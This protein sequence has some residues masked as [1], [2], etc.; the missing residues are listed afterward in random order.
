MIR[1]PDMLS[2]TDAARRL[3][4]HP[5]R[6]R[7]LLAAG[8]LTG[9]KLGERW[10][11]DGSS[12]RQRLADA[13]IPGRLL[14]PKDAWAT[15]LLACGEPTLWFSADTRWR[16]RTQLDERGLIGLAPRLRRRAHR[17]RYIAHPGILDRLAKDRSLSLTGI[18]AATAHGLDIA[19]GG[20]L[21]AYIP[22]AAHEPLVATYALEPAGF[23]EGNLCLRIVPDA[24]WRHVSSRSAAPLAA[25]ALDLAEE[26]DSRSARVG[27]ETL[28]ALDA[29]RL[30]RAR[31]VES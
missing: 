19:G 8:E 3:G 20:E 12:V 7:A 4:V 15:V 10:V 13:P 2:T 1:G 16:L 24:T 11:I 28:E 25:V 22:Q 17:E 31:P 27:H 26:P 18:S 21:D 9:Q 23:S 30:W 5:S 14:T 29:Q 6:V